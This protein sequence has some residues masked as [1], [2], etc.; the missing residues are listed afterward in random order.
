VADVIQN[1]IACILTPD[2]RLSAPSHE[3]STI[4]L[5]RLGCSIQDNE[6]IAR[7]AI[8][9]ISGH[10]AGRF[11]A[12]QTDFVDMC[13]RTARQPSPGAKSSSRIDTE[14]LRHPAK[15]RVLRPLLRCAKPRNTSNVTNLRHRKTAG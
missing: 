5:R 11:I 8:G 7:R 15:H 13:G 1:P 4:N 3:P 6:E 9:P 12:P 14:E 2:F 10:A